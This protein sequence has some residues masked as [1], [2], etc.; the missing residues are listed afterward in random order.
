MRFF[1]FIKSFYLFKKI[2]NK[3]NNLIVISAMGVAIISY[4]LM[5]EI[6]LKLKNGSKLKNELNLVG[7]GEIKKK[8]KNKFIEKIPNY[9]NLKLITDF[10]NDINQNEEELFKFIS[11][12]EK[13]SYLFG[14]SMIDL[15]EM[16]TYCKKRINNEKKSIYIDSE[17][18]ENILKSF[19]EG[20]NYFE[21]YGINKELIKKQIDIVNLRVILDMLILHMKFWKSLK[22]LI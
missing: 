17:N 6:K 13:E 21:K 4:V 3:K 14:D 10:L 8:D 1:K 11:H 19:N 16:E 9:I 12:H 7:C 15:K 22:I 18:K 20:E 2:N 5:D